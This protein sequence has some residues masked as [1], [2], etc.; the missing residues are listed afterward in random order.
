MLEIYNEVIT[1]L[2]N[3][4][5]TNLQIR[6]DMKKGCFVENLSEQLIQNGEG[7]AAESRAAGNG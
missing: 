3:P 1:D 4:G 5:A 7:A 6:E 2:L